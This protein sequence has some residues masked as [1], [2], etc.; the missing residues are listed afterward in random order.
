MKD[1]NKHL[2][3]LRSLKIYHNTFTD[4]SIKPLTNLTYLEINGP[5]GIK[6][7]LK[8]TK[9]GLK[10]LTNL[11][12]LKTTGDLEIDEDLT[13]LPLEE[14]NLSDIVHKLHGW[15]LPVGHNF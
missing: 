5:F 8:I 14:L 6:E 15:N 4:D 9:N 13:D 1:A 3:N 12:K 11:K 7:K 10:Q 2:T